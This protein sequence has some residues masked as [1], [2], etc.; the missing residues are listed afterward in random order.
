L[1]RAVLSRVPEAEEVRFVC[2]YL[3]QRREIRQQAI[4]NLIW[5]LL[6]STEFCLNH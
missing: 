1:Y 2:E 3:A 6:A 5:G 4:S